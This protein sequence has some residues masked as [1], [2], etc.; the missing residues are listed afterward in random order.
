MANKKYNKTERRG[1]PGGPNE[2]VTHT[3]IEFST[4]G[5]KMGSPDFNKPFNI[6]PSSYITMVDV[7]FP[8]MGTDNLGNSELMTPGG[9]YKFPGNM[10]FEKP[11]RA[12][13]GIEVPKR[14]GT[15]P[16]YDD[17]GNVVS[18]S[19]HLMRA[20]QLEDGTWVAFPSLFQN[21]DEEW[22]DMSREEDWMKIYKEALKRGEVINFGDDKDAAIAFGKGSWK[23]KMQSGGG[24]MDKVK[25]KIKTY[26]DD[27]EKKVK[28][29]YEGLNISEKYPLLNK[30]LST[31]DQY[32]LENI[33]I[34]KNGELF[35]FDIVNNNTGEVDQ[36]LTRFAKRNYINAID[37]I[38]TAK[39]NPL[40]L[41][42]DKDS[43]EDAVNLVKDTYKTFKPEIV[44]KVKDLVSFQDGGDIDDI[45]SD[46][47]REPGSGFQDI[48]TQ[49]GWE[50]KK[51]VDDAG[52]ALYYTRRNG[53]NNWMDLQI[54]GNE[55]P[56]RATKAEVF[57]ED[58]EE[59]FGTEDQIAEESRRK[60]EYNKL[61]SAR[62][63]IM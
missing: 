23:K 4:E 54:E 6:I 8:V 49:G 40:D 37:L 18:E 38:D 63:K 21:E 36:R 1:L 45:E 34:A 31:N 9:E 25:D 57:G 50:Y 24:L 53:S 2:T 26:V 19:T 41:V 52:N 11:I 33:S 20:E 56:L 15:R 22:V 59:W 30:F 13:D 46:M 35:D 7:P 51:E 29:E 55:I 44:S 17:K 5:Y 27:T 60:E 12:Q 16:N 62:A 43:R 48:R 58:E 32:S 61:L 14:K 10:V 39:N 42:L 28:D 3:N 47:S